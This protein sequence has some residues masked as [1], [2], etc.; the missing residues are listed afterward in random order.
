MRLR[1]RIQ[2]WLEIFRF[3]NLFTV[4]GDPIAGCLLAAALSRQ[5][6]S[7]F[8][9]TALAASSLSLYCFGLLQNDLR[10]LDEDAELRPERP[11][12]SGRVKTQSAMKAMLATASLGLAAAAVVSMAS[13]VVAMIVLGLVSAYNLGGK[14]R[15]LLGPALMGACR[16]SSFLLGVAAVGGMEILRPCAVMGFLL[17][18]VHIGT[19]TR[20][21][22]F[23]TERYDG[24]EE[25]FRPPLCL[26]VL[27]GPL[28]VW[29]LLGGGVSPESRTGVSVV[30]SIILFV[31]ALGWTTLTGL[32]LRDG[33]P[34]PMT[35]K[36][37]GSWLRALIPIQSAIIA[38]TGFWKTALVLGAFLLSASLFAGRRFQSS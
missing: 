9:L 22:R 17:M 4:P 38:A 10:D 33:D 24:G 3:P 12:P 23:D 11:L 25:R 18:T 26:L 29:I 15:T 2:P 16:G 34:P 19:V 13:L 7:P 28:V 6:A 31:A 27:L 8:A 37:I 14:K 35:R 36:A 32:N 20:L 21:A 1:N 30:V 5:E